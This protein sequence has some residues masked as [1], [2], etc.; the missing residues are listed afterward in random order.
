MLQICQNLGS[1][2]ILLK[3][4]FGIVTYMLYP[5]EKNSAKAEECNC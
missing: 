2:A 4:D 5:R 3:Q 1:V